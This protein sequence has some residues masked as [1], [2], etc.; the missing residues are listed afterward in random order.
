V[1]AEQVREKGTS[2][3]F[4]RILGLAEALHDKYELVSRRLELYRLV[5]IGVAI[6]ASAYIAWTA[7][8]PAN[9]DS[10][11]WA[12]V[13]L[14]FTLAVLYLG[15][16]ELLIRRLRRRSYPDRLA[17]K[18]ILA[19]VRETEAAISRGEKWSALDRAQLQIRLS[20]LELE[21]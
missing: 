10:K 17:L 13:L 15:A 3:D 4:E 16:I 2:E 19:L 18:H 7:F 9:Q 11:R 6:S 14:I 21:P 12:L 1:T 8:F 5:Q 20:R